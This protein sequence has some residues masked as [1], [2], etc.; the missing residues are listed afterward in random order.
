MTFVWVLYVWMCQEPGDRPGRAWG[1]CNEHRRVVHTTLVEC[2]R[3]AEARERAEMKIRAFC[4][5][6]QDDGRYDTDQQ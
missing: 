3:D 4:R 2:R 5:R 1:A 6:R